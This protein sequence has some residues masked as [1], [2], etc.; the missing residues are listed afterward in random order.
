M[1]VVGL[2]VEYNPFHNGHLYHLQRSLAVCQTEFAVGAMSGNFLQRGEPAAFDKWTRAATAIAGGIDVVFELPVAFAAHSAEYFAAG[3]VGLL[4]AT[5]IVTHLSFGSE[6]GNLASIQALSR[7]LADEPA[8]LQTRLREEMAAGASYPA[9][10]A[11]AVLRYLREVAP[12]P[13][14][15]AEQAF[16]LMERPNNILSIEYLKA[17]HSTGSTIRPVTVPRVRADYHDPFFPAGNIASATAIRHA[18]QAAYRTGETTAAALSAV[19]RF[20]PAAVREILADALNRGRGPVFWESLA[21]AVLTVLRRT[22]TAT[23][24]S[25][26]GIGEG[27]E[28]RLLGAAR[29]AAT[30]QEL[31]EALQTKRYAR[32]RLQR[33]L[34]H[35]LLNY[36]AADAA[37]YRAI[38]PQYLR[39]LAFSPKGKIL[40]R[41]MR[42]TASVPIIHRPAKIIHRPAKYDSRI[43][44]DEHP[45]LLHRMLW[46]DILATDIYALALPDPSAR[47]GGLDFIHR[48][49]TLP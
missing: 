12:L 37:A 25:I 31:L 13:D 30:V 38:G 7:L 46:L 4:N 49:N 22:D 5:G 44:A 2:V 9:A 8:Q 16:S 17:L 6:S 18:L 14:V 19:A 23:L 47:R 39:V 28:N 41:T 20:I 27:L 45:D 34:V 36:T 15:T 1:N 24:A 43:P 11:K 29:Q 42:D 48:I 40:L 10:R 35:T 26:A 21:P 3:A 32:T 33:I